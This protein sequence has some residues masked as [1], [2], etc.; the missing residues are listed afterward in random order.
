MATDNASEKSSGGKAGPV[1]KVEGVV[2]TDKQYH[3]YQDLVKYTTDGGAAY[4]WNVKNQGNTAAGKEA[5]QGLYE[6][7]KNSENYK[8]NQG[9][10]Q[11]DIKRKMT[12]AE[13]A[14]A[15]PRSGAKLNDLTKASVDYAKGDAANETPAQRHQRERDQKARTA[16]ER[17]TPAGSAPSD[18][19][20]SQH[21]EYLNSLGM[22]ANPTAGKP[23]ILAPW[24]S[25]VDQ[26]QS[27]A[28]DQGRGNMA[29]SQRAS[30]APWVQRDSNGNLVKPNPSA[31]TEFLN[32]A[33][34]PTTSAGSSAAATAPGKSDPVWL[35]EDSSKGSAIN[36]PSRGHANDPDAPRGRNDNH[37]GNI[38]QLSSTED[39]VGQFFDDKKWT[40]QFIADFQRKQGL[41]V[42][43][44]RNQST[45]DAWKGLVQVAAAR[46]KTGAKVSP[47]S[48]LGDIWDSPD[49]KG[50]GRGAAAGGTETRTQ[51]SL[52]NRG[53]A[54]ALLNHVFQA[55]LGRAVTED[56]VTAFQNALNTQEKANPKVSTGTG[57]ADG[58]SSS[59]TDTGGI[60][61]E[62][63]AQDYL[64]AEKGAEAN[65][66]TVGVDYFQAALNAIG[67]GA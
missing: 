15:K 17:A 65:A 56:E 25:T 8:H 7:F 2:L 61:P 42:T 63:Y 31:T 3:Q 46:Y 22:Q 16:A 36:T 59:V 58:S 55:K 21:Q 14:K 45:L 11:K 18:L 9:L 47:Y 19:Q 27:T 51:I 20:K 23:G 33:G 43:G 38:T 52:T 54:K 53:G 60:D 64:M 32:A 67:A 10:E 50:K 40:P 35:G 62:Q 28:F 37:V 6:H 41:A 66:R 29:P 1:H 26:G 4:L 12:D 44:Q 57:S 48:M 13:A 39:A 5:I 34:V 30:D 49:Q 24:G